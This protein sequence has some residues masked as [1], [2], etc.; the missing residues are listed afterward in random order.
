MLVFLD[1]FEFIG[2]ASYFL[3]VLSLL[4]ADDVVNDM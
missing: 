3:Q 4:N 2:W 1:N